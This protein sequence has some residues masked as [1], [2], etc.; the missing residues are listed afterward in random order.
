MKSRIESQ[1]KRPRDQ[2]QR[3]SYQL[4]SLPQMSSW[5]CLPSSGVRNACHHAWLLKM[6]S[7]NQ[8]QVLVYDKQVLNV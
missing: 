4:A 3:R 7:G 6:D 1:G 2:T 8:T 5:L